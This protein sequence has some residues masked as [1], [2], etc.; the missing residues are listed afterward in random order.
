[1]VITTYVESVY[2][3]GRLTLQPTTIAQY[4]YAAKSLQ[5]FYAEPVDELER[6][7]A[8]C[9]S[10][11]GEIRGLAIPKSAWW[12]SLVLFLYDTGARLSAALAVSPHELS[13]AARCVVLNG[14]AAKTGIEQSIN[15]SDQTVAAVAGH[16]ATDRDDSSRSACD[17]NGN[18]TD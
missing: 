2:V 1:M 3:P 12:S 10:L 14:N 13:L 6:M 17:G 8:A 7:I 5:K 9:R 11:S 16:Y 4:L 18:V 15:L